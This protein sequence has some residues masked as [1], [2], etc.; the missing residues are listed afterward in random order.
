MSKSNISSISDVTI[1]IPLYACI[2]QTRTSLENNEIP[3]NWWVTFEDRR[4]R[5]NIVLTLAI[6]YMCFHE[7]FL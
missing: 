5:S 2:L 3:L 1:G 7:S 4:K 6:H